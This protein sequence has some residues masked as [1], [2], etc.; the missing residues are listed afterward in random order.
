MFGEEFWGQCCI[1]F[2]RVPMDKK[3]IKWVAKKIVMLHTEALSCGWYTLTFHRLRQ[4][5]GD[6]KTDEQRATEYMK[7]VESKFDSAKGSSAQPSS[8]FRYYLNMIYLISW[9]LPSIRNFWLISVTNMNKFNLTLVL[10][11]KSRLFHQPDIRLWPG[12]EICYLIKH[13]REGTSSTCTLTPAMTRRM[14]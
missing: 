5:H 6:G 3:Q 8:P 4:K 1:V 11:A 10:I 2:T 9:F 7:V 13:Y 14:K 12:S